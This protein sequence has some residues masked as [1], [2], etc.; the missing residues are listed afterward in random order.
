M[1]TIIALLQEY[2][3][4]VALP[5]IVAGITQALKNG[6]NRFFR[7]NHVGM[8]IIHFI[9]IVLG[10]CGGML[11]P[12]ETMQEKILIGGALGQLSALIYKG[13]TRTFATKAKL[14]EVASRRENG[15]A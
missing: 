3:A 14:Q 1:E 15:D 10:V 5:V 7:S 9:P 11:L 4:Y 2:G 8:R 12:V 6:F 13:V